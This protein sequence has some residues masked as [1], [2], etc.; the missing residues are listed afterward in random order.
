MRNAEEGSLCL[1]MVLYV[2]FVASSILKESE[3]I[4][5]CGFYLSPAFIFA[6]FVTRAF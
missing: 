2:L 3:G 4:G 1:F 5:G 6:L